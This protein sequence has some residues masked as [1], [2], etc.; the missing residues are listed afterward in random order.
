MRIVVLLLALTRVAFAAPPSG[1]QCAPGTVKKDV[2]CACPAGHAEKRDAENI[3]TCVVAAP[4]GPSYTLQFIKALADEDL[5]K[6]ADLALK[7]DASTDV[8][9]V[10]ALA[11]SFD[12]WLATT[13]SLGPKGRCA[14]LQQATNRRFSYE[15]V[16]VNLLQKLEKRSPAMQVTANKKIELAR[17][18]DPLVKEF[19]TCVA[20]AAKTDGTAK[21]VAAF[22]VARTGLLA[23]CLQKFANQSMLVTSKVVVDGDGRVVRRQTTSSPYSADDSTTTTSTRG[24]V[25]AWLRLERMPVVGRGYAATLLVRDGKPEAPLPD[26]PAPPDVA[27]PPADAKKTPKGVSY[28][29]L[30]QGPG[31]AKPS[32]T[33]KVKVHYTGW[34]IDGKMI[35]STVSRGQPDEFSLSAV[36]AGFAD[37][38]LIM[39]VGDKVRFW[40]PE[41]LAYKGKGMLVFDIELFEIH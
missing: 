7:L 27:A 28:K 12:A 31:G 30:K 39:S 15:D 34:Q 11:R 38:L 3:A 19:D 41:E 26:P 33:S 32:T 22:E 2:G 24:C 1:Y 20:E 21:L 17:A 29:V 5:V 14:A 36:V 10:E 16:W 40:I 9:A 6:A 4:A 37:G 8:K 25:D 13:R 18:I 23:G 35:D